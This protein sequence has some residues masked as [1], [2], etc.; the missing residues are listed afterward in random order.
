MAKYSLLYILEVIYINRENI[1]ERIWA[2]HSKLMG[3]YD[4]HTSS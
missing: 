4:E 1:M 2:R 3:A